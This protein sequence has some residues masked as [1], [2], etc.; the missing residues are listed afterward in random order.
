MEIQIKCE[1]ESDHIETIRKYAKLVEKGDSY[2]KYQFF[3]VYA[4]IE[5]NIAIISMK[6]KHEKDREKSEKKLLAMIDKFGLKCIS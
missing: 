4:Q 3:N 2:E 6:L 5:G 1:V